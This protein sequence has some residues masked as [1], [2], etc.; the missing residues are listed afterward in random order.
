[1]CV[2]NANPGLR[3]HK[4]TARQRPFWVFFFSARVAVGSFPPHMHPSLLISF[5]SQRRF[6]VPPDM[7]RSGRRLAASIR[8]QCVCVCV[9]GTADVFSLFCVCVCVCVGNTTRVRPSPRHPTRTKRSSARTTTNRRIRT[10]TRKVSSEFD[11]ENET[12]MDFKDQI[13]GEALMKWVPRASVSSMALHRSG[14]RIDAVRPA[15]RHTLERRS[16]NHT[17]RRI[18]CRTWCLSIRRLCHSIAVAE[19]DQL[20]SSHFT[21]ENTNTRTVR[22]KMHCAEFV[23]NEPVVLDIVLSIDRPCHDLLSALR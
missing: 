5:T 15:R 10:T 13:E 16:L 23:T 7:G 12:P 6:P 17:F 2:C 22:C 11:F 21:R 14:R 8:R 9:C 19:A 3:Y 18:D 20:D 4:G 1:M